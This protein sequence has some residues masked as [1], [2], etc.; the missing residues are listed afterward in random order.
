[1]CQKGGSHRDI[2]VD[3][4]GFNQAS[5]PLMRHL[6]PVCVLLTLAEVALAGLSTSQFN[7]P[8]VKYVMK[9]P[10]LSRGAGISTA[11]TER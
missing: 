4:Y 1:M 3:G 8:R 9:S 6:L 11:L 2:V 5:G 10:S 7:H